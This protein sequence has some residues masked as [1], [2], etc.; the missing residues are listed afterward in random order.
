ML[1]L[2]RDLRYRPVA[3]AESMD[4]AAFYVIAL[5]G[6]ALG[7][8]ATALA[9]ATVARGAASLAVLRLAQPAPWIGRELRAAGRLFLPR[10]LPLAAV[11][12]VSLL[13]G[14]VPA[15]A[16][17]ASTR[18]VGF[19]TTASAV[20]GYALA[21]ATAAQR[22]ALPALARAR[23]ATRP[24]TLTNGI[25]IVAAITCLA[26]VALAGLP[27]I[28]VRPLLGEAW[29]DAAGWLAL[30]G[31]ALVVAAPRGLLI[32]ALTQ[33]GASNAVLR[34]QVTATG[35]YLCA[36]V[37]A[38]AIAGPIGCAVA[39]VGSRWL[40]ALVV[41]RAAHRQLGFALQGRVIWVPVASAAA[42]AALNVVGR[43]SA[44][45]SVAAACVLMGVG[46]LLARGQ[47]TSLVRG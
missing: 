19:F 4:M 17:G 43:I 20:L 30:I 29:A 5:G 24:R 39:Y 38:V 1:M 11:A 31:T 37:L 12:A 23:P 32:A 9:L 15:L 22:V 40:W 36:A 47:L 46:A 28:W 21:G 26:L 18:E 44:V 6:L 7:L 25:D 45:G 41:A 2:E 35:M 34:A 14:L 10:G 13:D 27:H 8:D 33:T 42:I 3:L 16:L